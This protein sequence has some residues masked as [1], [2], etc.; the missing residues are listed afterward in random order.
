MPILRDK[1]ICRYS[2]ITLRDFGPSPILPRGHE[3]EGPKLSFHIPRLAAPI[4]YKLLHSHLGDKNSRIR[5]SVCFCTNIGN[6]CIQ[7]QI[8]CDSYTQVF[9]AFNVFQ[10]STLKGVLSLYFTRWFICQLHHIVLNGL[11]CHSPFPSSTALTINV[12]LKSQC[13]LFSLDFVIANIIISK[14]SYFRLNV[15]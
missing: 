4:L 2:G 6:I 13:I 1:L 15:N 11:K 9:N 12:S 5:S 10:Y 8:V 7:F 14:E 3:C